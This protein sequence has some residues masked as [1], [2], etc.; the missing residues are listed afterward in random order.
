MFSNR[1]Y[2]YKL[3]SAKNIK[4]SHQR[5]RIMEYLLQHNRAHPTVEQIFEFLRKELPSL[6]KTTIYNTLNVFVEAGLVNV[7]NI[8]EAESRYDVITETHGHFRCENC[9][10]IS[11]F[12]LN[13][14]ELIT[15]ELCGFKITGKDVY[16]KGICPKCLDGKNSK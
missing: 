13:M 8:D 5:V 14:N 12:Q 1:D 3:L 7:V 6:S 15:S 4:P 11:D 10:M 2:G 9:G 16:F